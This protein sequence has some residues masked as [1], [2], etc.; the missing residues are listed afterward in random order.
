MTFSRTFNQHGLSL[1]YDLE[2]YFDNEVVLRLNRKFIPASFTDF[3]TA[4]IEVWGSTYV[5]FQDAPAAGHEV[6]ATLECIADLIEQ[7]LI[8]GFKPFFDK[9]AH[10]TARQRR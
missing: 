8:P 9:H 6:Y 2:W 3:G 7:V 4:P 1:P 10:S 5:L